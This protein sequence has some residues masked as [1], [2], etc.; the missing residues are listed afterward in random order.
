MA[1]KNMGKVKRYRHSFYSGKQRAMRVIGGVI[2]L[3][4]L[5]VVGWLVGPAVVNFGSNVWYSMTRGDSNKPQDNSQPASAASSGSDAAAGV[6]TPTPE[7]TATPAPATDLSQGSWA[8]VQESSLSNQQAIEDTAQKLADQGVRYAVVTLKDDQ[9][10]IY[11]NSALPEA[12]AGIAPTAFD[13]KAVA[14]ALQQKNIVPV[15]AICAFKDPIAAA[16]QRSMAVMYQDTDYLWLDAAQD[17][18]GKP[19]LNPYSQQAQAFITGMIQEAR[20][21]GYE[22]IWLSGV[23]FPTKAGRDMASYGDTAGVSEADCLKNLIQTWQQGGTCW[24]EYPLTVATGADVSLTGGSINDLGIEN[25][26]VKTDGTLDEETQQ[27]LQQVKTDSGATYIGV[28]NGDSFTV[29][30]GD[31]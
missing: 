24:I 16:S 30:V 31:K 6:A 18:G 22:Q 14:Q 4:V 26:A 17:A 27:T 2:A 21:M 28:R 15:A 12:A 19:W 5:F 23:Q 7:P 20:D 8:F 10:S 11:Y 13:A 1:K 3:L 29:E 9:G 25:L